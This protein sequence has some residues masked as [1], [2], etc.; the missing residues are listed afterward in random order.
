VNRPP[1]HPDIVRLIIAT[2]PVLHSRRKGSISKCIKGCKACEYL[3]LKAK[4]LDQVSQ[5]D[6]IEN[7]E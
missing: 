5:I 6:V 2:P 1:L 4:A 3:D 7:N